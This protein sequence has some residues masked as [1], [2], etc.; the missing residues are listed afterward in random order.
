MV[1]IRKVSGAKYEDI[2]LLQAGDIGAVC[3]LAHARVG[4]ILGDPG[5]V[6]GGCS[7]AHP[8]LSVRVFPYEEGDYPALVAAVEELCAEGPASYD[9]VGP[10]GTKPAHSHHRAHP[11]G[12]SRSADD[13]PFRPAGLFLRSYDYL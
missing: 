1:Q 13:T 5:P 9:G 12:G 4:D 6:P 2:G 11:A 3:G 7:F 8:L 10:G